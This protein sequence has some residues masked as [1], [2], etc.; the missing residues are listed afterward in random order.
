MH[1]TDA[2]YR[3]AAS[4]IVARTTPS[5]VVVDGRDA[6]VSGLRTLIIRKNDL[7]FHRWRPANV[8]YLYLFRQREQG[9][10]AVEISRFDP[11][12]AAVDQE[13]AAVRKTLLS[14]SGQG[15]SR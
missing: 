12:V 2:G 7:F 3:I 5:A 9:N 4:H 8:T 11:L 13:I 6:R 15:G 10:N 14:A 1:L